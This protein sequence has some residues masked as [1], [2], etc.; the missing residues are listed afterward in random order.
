MRTPR[1][2]VA[3]LITTTLT[4]G[5][6]A[7]PG[8]GTAGLSVEKLPSP[9][10]KSALRVT[11]DASGALWAQAY[12]G[13][14]FLWNVGTRAWD[15]KFASRGLRAQPAGGNVAVSLSEPQGVS[16][17]IPLK[18]MLLKNGAATPTAELFIPTADTH[19]LL[20]IDG[21][22]TLY[23][24]VTSGGS[25]QANQKTWVYKLPL[26]ATAWEKLP[27]SISYEGGSQQ[28]FSSDGRL[29]DFTT[30]GIER[31]DFVEPTATRTV[32]LPCDSP[33]LHGCTE[34][35][36]LMLA[37]GTD[38]LYVLDMKNF[39]IYRLP[40]GDTR[41]VT[42]ANP[43]RPATAFALQGQPIL[44]R[45]GHVWLATRTGNSKVDTGSVQVLPKGAKTWATLNNEL[46]RG[47][48]LWL[49][50]SGELLANDGVDMN[51]WVALLH[52]Q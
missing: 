3:C 41:W 39:G 8:T 42:V 51:T 33:L 35:P 44:D 34:T 9:A 20:A 18:A 49:L 31:V 29:I 4:I 15:F 25:N 52:R 37:A 28:V 23:A 21:R 45:Q 22:D 48:E 12:G 46:T 10:N 17:P 43:G 16:G 36:R 2:F 26:G 6:S 19:E 30:R 1:A 13:D 5:C 38:D 7:P 50:P 40:E 27:G 14:I 47:V 32:L 24:R 11:S